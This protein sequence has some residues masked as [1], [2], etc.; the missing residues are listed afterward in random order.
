MAR[1]RHS[2]RKRLAA[3]FLSSV[4]KSSEIKVLEVLSDQFVES[5][6]RFEQNQFPLSLTDWSNLIVMRDNG[7]TELF[8][9]DNWF[10]DAV[11]LQEFS[12]I[13]VIPAERTV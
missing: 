2:E 9:F 8:T 4:Q 10:R 12:K 1:Y 3:E 5:K 13:H 6:T 7:L 11:K